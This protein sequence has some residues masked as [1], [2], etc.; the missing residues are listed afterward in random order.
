MKF[1]QDSIAC[2]RESEQ[3]R[4]VEIENLKNELLDKNICDFEELADLENNKLKSLSYEISNKHAAIIQETSIFMEDA[5]IRFKAQIDTIRRLLL[6]LA[7]VWDIHRDKCNNLDDTMNSDFNKLKNNFK[8]NISLREQN[9]ENSLKKLRQQTSDDQLT[10]TLGQVEQQLKQIKANFKD[11]EKVQIEKLNT[12]DP[13]YSREAKVYIREIKN[14]FGSLNEFLLGPNV[15]DACND[16]ALQLF[17]AVK[18]IESSIRTENDEVDSEISSLKSSLNLTVEASSRPTTAGSSSR[19]KTAW[20]LR[21]GLKRSSQIIGDDTSQNLDSSRP[22]TAKS[23]A[24]SLGPHSTLYIDQLMDQSESS[25]P[26]R[27]ILLIS[28]QDNT[29]LEISDLPNYIQ[30]LV[31]LDEDITQTVE[32]IKETFIIHIDQYEEIATQ[33]YQEKTKTLI[34]NMQEEINLE[35]QLYEQKPA[36]IKEH[37]YG[38]RKN[39]V[40]EHKLRVQRHLRAINEKLDEL[41][42]NYSKNESE[43]LKGQQKYVEFLREFDGV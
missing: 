28:K 29:K 23:S 31:L 30:P 20:S 2:F 17:E 34:E 21:G 39:E 40:D 13:K 10:G 36:Q 19:P 25:N 42:F 9:L 38:E 32:K 5:S 4:S 22:T 8:H 7:R 41:K 43:I 24:R 35:L 27:T 11:Y 14:F 1:L 6:A 16:E 12:F 26:T 3:K 18:K 33:N 37:V 15:A